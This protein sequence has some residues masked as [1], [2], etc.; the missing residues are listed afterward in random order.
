MIG[1]WL[2]ALAAPEPAPLLSPDVSAGLRGLV[3]VV[4]VLGLVA[5]FAWLVRRGVFGPL[6]R[7]GP[8]A[9]AVETAVSLGERRSVVV[10]AVEGR[11]LL[12]GLAPGQVT[13]LT[14]LRAPA[15]TFSGALERAGAEPT[16]VN[17]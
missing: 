1:G 6:G 12:L 4:V 11:R 17:S 13:M 16:R 9:I 5:L 3:A 15:A 2:L 8:S 10:V 7:R 14:E